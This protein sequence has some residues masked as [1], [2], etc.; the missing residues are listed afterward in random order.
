MKWKAGKMTFY[1]TN[2]D[3]FC[4]YSIDLTARDWTVKSA[5]IMSI[6]VL[7]LKNQ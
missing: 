3:A 7:T 5:E 4:K 6:D 1:V 2:S